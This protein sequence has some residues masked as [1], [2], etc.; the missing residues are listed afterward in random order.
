MTPQTA[1]EWSGYAMARVSKPCRSYEWAM[2]TDGSGLGR[3][4][5]YAQKLEALMSYQRAGEVWKMPGIY[6]D[7][8]FAEGRPQMG[9][10]LV[11]WEH[12]K[13]TLVPCSSN[14]EKS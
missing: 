11:N 14:E 8:G 5:S 9:S 13:L 4:Q 7:D 1:T 3:P 12:V 2:K 10:Q 6:G